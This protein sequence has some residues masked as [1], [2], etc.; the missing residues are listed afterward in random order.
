[1][2]LKFAGYKSWLIFVVV[3]CL[4]DISV[5]LDIPFFRQAFGFI[6]L[7]IIP[8]VLLV[9]IFDLN[10]TENIEKLLLAVGLSLSF[11]LIFGFFLNNLLLALGYK[12]P[13]STIFVLMPFNIVYVLL[14]TISYVTNNG[15][16]ISL[17]KPSLLISE[18]LLLIVPIFFPTLSIF[19][20]DVMN[21]T[22]NNSI[23]I[24]LILLI[25]FY[26]I[27][28]CIFHKLLTNKICPIIIFLMSIS[29]IV[30]LSLRS[31][32][33]IG[34]DSHF[35]YY[36]FRTTLD[37]LSWGILGDSTLNSCLSISLL[38]TIYQSILNVDPEYLYKI[39]YSLI[40]SISPV[41]IYIISK[42]YVEV[43]HAFLASIFFMSQLLFIHTGANART[44]IA[45]LFFAL[46]MLV[47]FSDEIALFKRKFI[48]IV[49]MISCLVSHYSTTYIFFFIVLLTYLGTSAIS[50][51]YSSSKNINF[52][53]VVLFFCLIFFWY[54][55]STEIPFEK[56]VHFFENTLVSL[57]N[58][59]IE[60]ARSSSVENLFGVNLKKKGI[61]SNINFIFNWAAILL[62]GAG[63]L[64]SIIKYKE[65]V[66]LETYSNKTPLL[67]TK[68][69][70]EYFVIAILCTG[71]LFLTITIPYLTKDYELSR[72]Y[73]ITTVI[74]SL[75][76]VIGGIVVSKILNMNAHLLILLIL[77]PNF[78]ATTDITYTTFGKPQ[79]I[80]LSSEGNQ[81]DTL[82]I[83]DE[84]TF[85]SRWLK[86]NIPSKSLTIYSDNF[87][88]SILAS[89]GLLD[90]RTE[91]FEIQKNQRVYGYI[92]LRSQSVIHNQLYPRNG[93]ENMYNDLILS[94]R[95][96]KIYDNAKSEI[97]F[98]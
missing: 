90:L 72:I 80:I 96:K 53:T 83:H 88:R 2:S 77:I 71:I 95:K 64:T 4:T 74:L 61:A 10:E 35:E 85:A 22:N 21:K 91:V 70:V 58:I 39:L 45:I 8:G 75:F 13:L 98:N 69:H 47:L 16:L 79:S 3:L 65:T 44:T 81:Y 92:Y 15:S 6:F 57:K 7:T 60:E 66:A 20:M 97:Y 27:F 36:F 33:I 14:A 23:L 67:E 37:N 43:S 62:L 56:S 50:C 19:G 41:I 76:F 63:I 28:L 93:T 78:F 38:P 86:E 25:S 55:L 68:I 42:K 12:A 89:Q 52:S 31:N 84:E 5:I 18:K 11:V 49:F 40:Y 73:G 34:N 9:G 1:M 59:F 94:P 54:S 29:L 17:S 48:F 46:S 87:G 24:S 32:H 30:L 26:I 51:K 82:Y